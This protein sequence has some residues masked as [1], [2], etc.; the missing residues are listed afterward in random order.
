MS[1]PL[2]VENVRAAGFATY[3]LLRN[4]TEWDKAEKVE[5]KLFQKEKFDEN[6]FTMPALG[7]GGPKA[8]VP[9]WSTLELGGKELLTSMIINER[10][11]KTGDDK[12]TTIRYDFYSKYGQSIMAMY[13]YDYVCEQADEED[14][15]HKFAMVEVADINFNA[16]NFRETRLKLF[17]SLSDEEARV[18]AAYD[19]GPDT[20]V[21]KKI[22]RD[23][24]VVLARAHSGKVLLYEDAASVLS[25]ATKPTDITKKSKFDGWIY[26][27]DPTA[28][29]K[30]VD[31]LVASQLNLGS[32]IRIS[33]A[34]DKLLDEYRGYYEADDTHVLIH[35][36]GVASPYYW[37]VLWEGVFIPWLPTKNFEA[38]RS[39]FEALRGKC[40][41]YNNA[42]LKAASVKA[43]F[44]ANKDNSSLIR[45][46][47]NNHY[48]GKYMS[49][50]KTYIQTP[51]AKKLDAEIRGILLKTQALV[52]ADFLEDF[53]GINFQRDENGKLST[54]PGTLVQHKDKLKA[55]IGGFG[56]ISYSGG[57]TQSLETYEILE[58]RLNQN[59]S[60]NNRSVKVSGHDFKVGEDVYFDKAPT[61]DYFKIEKTGIFK[62]SSSRRN[63]D[64]MV[65]I[66]N[67][68]VP[69]EIKDTNLGAIVKR[70]D[71]DSYDFH[72]FICGSS[73]TESAEDLE[74]F[75]EI[76]NYAAL[77]KD[78]LPE[79]NDV[80]VNAW[81][82]AP[83]SPPPLTLCVIRP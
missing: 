23:A 62:K 25:N 19:K 55:L 50:M 43:R 2:T 64:A 47:I 24:A 45:T 8:T 30:S 6:D 83:V 13:V 82:A 68:E 20:S 75:K 38:H 32:R 3:N 44:K 72:C 28:E 26:T 36:Y 60:P 22:A 70:S 69:T 4:N 46:L 59:A 63:P 58:V 52:C 66:L 37:I 35:N 12:R 16:T 53:H 31:L 74:K 15:P 54:V 49:K 57:Y 77:F 42:V 1:E 65:L 11:K 80:T 7:A 48:C 79:Q 5:L 17:P 33:K 78:R 18:L 67:K 39:Q 40:I 73:P 61:K 81:V 29:S 10:T 34:T 71:K 14:S 56:G 41:E 9:K 21:S 27:G 76:S 51:G